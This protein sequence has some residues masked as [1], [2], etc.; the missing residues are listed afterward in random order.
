MRGWGAV[1]RIQFVA[2][3]S[4]CA[5]GFLLGVPIAVDSAC[6]NKSSLISN[7]VISKPLPCACAYRARGMPVTW[8]AVG[9]IQFVAPV[10]E[11]PRGFSGAFPSEMCVPFGSRASL[12]VGPVQLQVGKT[13]K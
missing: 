12:G 9:R 7:P 10:L 2:P 3:I 1:G 4:E 8:G 6:N 13:R 11:W 5:C